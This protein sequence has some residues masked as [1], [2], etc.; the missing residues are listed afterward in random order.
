MDVK[1]LLSVSISLT[2][3]A[4]FPSRT[5]FLPKPP[6]IQCATPAPPFPSAVSNHSRRRKPPKFPERAAFPESLPL[7]S[8]NP[9]SIYRDIQHLARL[10]KIREAL[11]VLD[12][13]DQRG[14]PVNPTTFSNLLSAASRCRSLSSVRKIH[15]HIRINGLQRNEFLL[16]KLVETYATC[17]SPMDAKRV[18]DDISPAN[19]YSWNA[20][21]RGHLSGGRRWD[22][23]PL[24]VF[25]AMR[26]AGVEVNEYTFSSL[27]KSFAGSPALTQGMKTHAL[28]IKNAF[29]GSPSL[30]KTVL[31][32]MY[33]KCGKPRMAMKVFD[34]MPVKDVVLWGT[35]VAGFAH[36]KL[37]WEALEC[38]RWMVNEGI[39]LNSVLITSIL[40]VLGDLSQRNFGREV[41]CYVIKQFRTYN[42][43][44]TIQSGLI[45]MYCKCRDLVS[46]RRVFNGSS[47]WNAVSWTAL[48][49]GYAYNDRSKQALRTIIWMQQ[50]GVKPDLVTIGT[51]LPICAKL[52]AWRQ[53]QEIHA[54]ALKHGFLNNVSIETSL[55]TMYSDCGSLASSCRVF[56]G[57]QRKNV[58]TWT[59]L[60]ESYL[61]SGNPT[62]ALEVFRL[63]LR[64]H[65]RPDA[66]S[67]CRTL[68]ASGELRALMLGR[69]IHAQVYKLKLQGAPFLVAEVVS[70]YGKCMDIT[71]AQKMFDGIHAKGSLTWTAII[72][73]YSFNKLY[74][75]ALNMLDRM[76]SHDFLPNH[77]T[78]DAVFSLCDQAGLVSRALEVFD[79]MVKKYKLNASQ[80]QLDCM[81]GLLT[82]A[83]HIDEVQR[84]MK[85]RSILASS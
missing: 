34:E 3:N 37:R 39:R 75:E 40:P 11:I 15:E 67:L 81:I 48:M 79:I 85:L 44:I 24:S 32:D 42:P 62:Y 43:T 28:L 73:A 9:K 57:M 16:V 51:A 8:K 47:E 10:G 64:A 65:H 70:M 12:Y 5:P 54:F 41:H 52:R 23:G 30:I 61:N 21:L 6:P 53:G 14:I 20:L 71:N 78:F 17:G 69:E 80:E 31:T 74:D 72:R 84:F 13:L 29:V 66:V 83:G 4:T 2:S 49:S 1:T 60:I 33:F 19:V 27:V 58:I 63:M 82:R 36:N 18:F 22:H 56:S 55:M 77:F 7:H 38:F 25:L 46:A 50:A 76:L 45:D 26:E 68:R 35:A 59:V